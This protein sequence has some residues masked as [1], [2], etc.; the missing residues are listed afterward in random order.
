MNK[1][2]Y[3]YNTFLGKGLHKDKYS[4]EYFEMS[5]FIL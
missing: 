2:N 1:N 3:H 4:T 5:V